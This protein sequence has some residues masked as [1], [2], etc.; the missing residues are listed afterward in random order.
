MCCSLQHIPYHSTTVSYI[1][2]CLL[3][4]KLWWYFLVGSNT[5]P[6]QCQLAP[7][8]CL[9]ILLSPFSSLS[10]SSWYPVQHQ[11]TL[12]KLLVPATTPSFLAGDLASKSTEKLCQLLIR[13]QR[14][15]FLLESSLQFSFHVLLGKLTLS[16]PFQ[17]CV[18]TLSLSPAPYFYNW[19]LQFA[20][21]FKWPK[22]Q[23]NKTTTTSAITSTTHSCSG[24]PLRGFIVHTNLCKIMHEQSYQL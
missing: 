4:L 20:S 17:F 14:D 11:F 10:V 8:Y 1:L 9:E 15:C 6:F 21:F 23:A 5:N 12:F 16:Y 19:I 18:F 7:Q 22:E 13:N 24:N 2:L 3:T